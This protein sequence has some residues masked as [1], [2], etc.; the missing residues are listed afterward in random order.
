MFNGVKWVQV[1]G[2]QIKRKDIISS[3]NLGIFYQRSKPKE[4][5]ALLIQKW[6]KPD[7][8]YLMYVVKDR[9]E[10]KIGHFFNI[11]KKPD[12][13]IFFVNDMTGHLLSEVPGFDCTFDELDFPKFF[14]QV[15]FCFLNI[16]KFLKLM[17][18]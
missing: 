15:L 17:M 16:F 11:F 12:G 14:S 8:W 9:T 7:T 4:D 5:H 18:H 2:H 1:D 3:K 6:T 10:D 13:Q